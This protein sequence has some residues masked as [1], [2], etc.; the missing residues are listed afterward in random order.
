MAGYQK[1]VADLVRRTHSHVGVC[2]D[3]DADRVAMTD[4]HGKMLSPPLLAA[5]VG[6]RLREKLGPDAVIAHNLACSWVV[7]DTLGDRNKVT[8]DGPTVMTPVGYGK[9]KV[10]MHRNPRIA[11]AAEHSGHYMFREFYSADSGML[12]GLVVLE[13]AAELHAQGKAF[14][15]VLADLRARYQESGEINFRLPPGRPADAAIAKAVAMFRSEAVRMYAVAED[16]VRQIADYPPAFKQAASDVRV[17]ARDWWFVMRK[18][19]TEGA[20]G[21]ICRLYVEAIGD[22]KLMEGKRDALVKLIGPEFRMA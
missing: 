3:G 19:G 8:G 5:L 20:A 6:K 1:M 10:A 17:E 15:P 7:A 2:F 22:R 18:S 12:A 9:I 13:L 4:E 16:G 14:S 21:D 11:F